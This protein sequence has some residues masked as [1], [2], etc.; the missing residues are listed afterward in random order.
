MK[1][2][3]SRL[4]ELRRISSKSQQIVAN[5]LKIGQTTYAGYE[6]DKSEPN[7]QMLLV[8]AEY[9]DVST[10]YLLGK[11]DTKYNQQELDFYNELKEKS[12]EDL[13]REYNLTLGDKAMSKDDER[14]LIRLMK[15]FVEDKD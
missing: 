11:T 14:V 12:I 8:L 5:E 15:S 9:Y 2:L 10:D 6:L 7:H 13:I 1:V 4:K 3:G